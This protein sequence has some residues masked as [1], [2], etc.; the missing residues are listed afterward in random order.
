VVG[1]S[2]PVSEAAL[3][4]ISPRLSPGPLFRLREPQLFVPLLKLE[5]MIAPAKAD[6]KVG[7]RNRPLRATEFDSRKNLIARSDPNLRHTA[8]RA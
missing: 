3:F 2:K 7:Q 8:D 4:V 5:P 6:V 1:F